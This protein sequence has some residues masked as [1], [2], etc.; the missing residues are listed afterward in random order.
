MIPV[1]IY[2][3]QGSQDLWNT[4]TRKPPIK[5]C[6]VEG[7]DKLTIR[8]RGHVKRGLMSSSLLNSILSIFIILSPWKYWLKH[9]SYRLL[10]HHCK[11]LC[12]S[13]SFFVG[14]LDLSFGMR[15]T[16]LTVSR[17][18]WKPIVVP[19]QKIK[20]QTHDSKVSATTMVLHPTHLARVHLTNNVSPPLKLT[21]CNSPSTWTPW[22]NITMKFCS[23]SNATVKRRATPPRRLQ[24]PSQQG[25]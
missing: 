22:Y 2:S 1:G 6:H 24:D 18:L 10:A 19:W 16:A 8:S 4:T 20:C 25:L 17:R 12:L 13:S 15:S 9:Q 11:L 14:T 7:D 3:L 23:P 5:A 21:S